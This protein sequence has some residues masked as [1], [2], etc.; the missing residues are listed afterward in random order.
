MRIH[1]RTPWLVALAGLLA[2]GAPS[3]D[4]EEARLAILHTTDLH[5]A[6]SPYDYLADRPASRGLVRI[7]TL[8]DSVRA[9]GVPTVL[10]DA[11][12]AIEGCPLVAVYQR[13]DRARPEPMMAAMSRMGYDAMAVG[14]HEFTYGREAAERARQQATFP[15]LAANVLRDED[16]RPAFAASVVRTAGPLRVGIA[17]VCTPAV[18]RLED[19][20]HWRG[21]RF[22]S[23]VDAARAEVARL[24]ET[25]GCDVVVLVAHTGL[26]EPVAMPSADGPDEHWGRL[27]AQVPGVDVLILGHSHE[28][29]AGQERGTT[30]VTQAGARGERLGRVDL[31]LERAD[32][33]TRWQVK[34]RSGR[35]L[36]ITGAT[37]EHAGLAGLAEPYHEATQ[38]ALARVIGTAARDFEPAGGR[39]ADHA[40]WEL[41]HRSQLE[42]TGADVS[43][44]ALFDPGA[45]IAAG[46]VT[47]RDAFRLYPYENSLAAVRLTGAELRE[48]LEHSARHFA[49]YRFEAGAPLADPLVPGYQYD[50]ARGVT[51]AVDLT[52]P[53]GQRIVDLSWRGRPLAPSETLVV[54]VNGY[55]LAGGG[56]YP[57]LRRAPRAAGGAGSARDAL[58]ATIER[59]GTLE[60]VTASG[61]TLLPDYVSAPERPHIDRLVREGLAPRAEVLRL[62][63]Y[64]PALRG[65]LAYW[66]A[67]AFGW[68]E[69]R[70]S[71]AFRDAP[72]SLAPWLDGLLRRK[73]LGEDGTRDRIR[74][75]D[76]ARLSPAQDWCERAARR[77]GYALAPTFDAAFRRGLLQGVGGGPPGGFRP[78]GGRLTRSQ[79]L[80]LVANAR[81]PQLRI[82]ETTDFHGAILGGAR[83][84]RSGRTIGGSAVLAAW[85][86]R[87]RAENPEGTVLVDGGDCYQGTMISNLQFGRPVVEQMNAL[88]YAAMAIGNH[89]FDWTA[90]TLARRVAGMRFAAL[91]ANMVERRTKRPPRWVRP[92]TVVS[93]VGVRVGVLGLCYRFT[94]AV[95]MPRYVAHLRFEDDSTTAARMVPALKRRS[96]LVIGVGHV[97]AETDAGRRALGG[98]LVRLARGVPGVGA[99][100]GGH[101]HNLVDDRVGGVP[102]MVAGSHGEAVAVCDLVVD[103]IGD[104]VVEARTTLV[105][106]FADEVTPDSAMAARAERWNDAVAAVAAAPVGRNART[107]RRDRRGES[108]VG[109][110]VADAMRSAAGADVALQ[111][112]GGLRA[113]L[114]EGAVTRGHVYEVMP[115]DNVLVTLDLT[116]AE[117]RRALEEGLAGGRV[118]QVS[119]I[120]Y[121]FDSGRPRFDR[122]VELADASGAPLDSARTYR[123]AV[124]DFMAS[125]GDDYRALEGGRN[126]SNTGV[127]VRE[128]LER[129]IAERCAGGAT[130]E[131]RRDGRIR[132]AGT[133]SPED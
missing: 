58:I 13:G 74:P 2:A 47:V 49:T 121:S 40:V 37:A 108:E 52:A 78:E 3:A 41:I 103:P 59:A 125:G 61:W 77:A 24:R 126:R 14:N 1:P 9:S 80:G 43:L 63:P 7:A 73:V 53:P 11:G 83:D 71:H 45:R 26:G 112:S 56:G 17:G 55:R 96:D 67:R 4:A 97:P 51:Y 90:D 130:L 72:D 35:L 54:A 6:L 76:P 18:P 122:V 118:T 124:N 5:G 19:E 105:R 75:N 21:L 111:N 94:P 69:E 113:D 85:V 62:G 29:I 123:V 87:L 100:F 39:A 81:F 27:L 109:N 79:V 66:L 20:D 131:V 34:R 10:V 33:G 116:G 57:A 127:L 16:G 119:G 93:R 133:V 32:S 65:D 98:D 88:R 120:R 25:E 99:W 36:E 106:T 110:L 8:V 107:L 102:V 95:T 129:Y 70:R 115:F 128:A 84:R 46:P 86:E 114:A 89:E 23:P 101:S 30:L 132:R 42:A 68:R 92:D 64:E 50:A 104:R 48:V 44:A 82:L 60:P 31:T 15:W 22:T 38:A 12:D 117:L 28:A 91:G